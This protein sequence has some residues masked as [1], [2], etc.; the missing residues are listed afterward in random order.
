M[1]LT[2]LFSSA[3]L[4]LSC[5]VYAEPAKFYANEALQKQTPTAYALSESNIPWLEQAHKQRQLDAEKL[6]NAL[7]QNKA[8]YKKLM[9]WEA[10]SFEQRMALLPEVFAIEIQ[11]FAITAPTLVINNTLYPQRAVNFVFDVRYPGA[12]LVYLNPDK[13]K[14]MEVYA[15]LA[16]L[17]HETR[18]AYQFQL[19]FKEQNLLAKGYLSAFK[20]QSNLSGASFSDFLTLLNEYEAFQFGNQVLEL[21]TDGKFESAMM[22]TFASQFNEHNHLKI[23]LLELAKEPQKGNLLE[24]FNAA[25]KEQYKLRY[26]E[27]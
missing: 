12:G 1:K 14:E 22:G 11:S 21:L 15:P 7:K 19:A 10:L 25:M 18:H 8:L 5:F 2:H 23:D 26:P 4:A 17:L 20:T 27:K 9:N 6:V 3:C 16:F 13:L 24:R